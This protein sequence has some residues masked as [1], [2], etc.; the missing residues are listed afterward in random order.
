MF[1]SLIVVGHF[2]FGGPFFNTPDRP[3]AFACIPILVWAALRHG[4]RSTAAAVVV[5][6]AIAIWGTA[7]GSGPFQGDA[8]HELLLLL[9]AFIGVVA[10]MGRLYFADGIRH[11][12]LQRHL[13]IADLVHKRAIGTV[14]QQSPDQVGQQLLM[15]AHGGINTAMQMRHLF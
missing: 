11:H 5:L 8:H 15:A 13:F 2:V 7:R 14:F 4:Q 3:L 1:G 10:V 12:C 6:A 9:Q